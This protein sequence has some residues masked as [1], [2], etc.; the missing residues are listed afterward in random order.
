MIIT[1]NIKRIAH[2]MNKEGGIEVIVHTLVQIPIPKIIKTIK[3]LLTNCNALLRANTVAIKKTKI[4]VKSST[5]HTSNLC[6]DSPEII[7]KDNYRIIN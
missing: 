1:I 5:L 2:F 6:T 7:H 4:K 3:A